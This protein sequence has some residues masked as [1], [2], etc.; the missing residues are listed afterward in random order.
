MWLPVVV[1]VGVER[2]SQVDVK[3]W[4][5]YYVGLYA[6]DYMFLFCKGVSCCKYCEGS[7]LLFFAFLRMFLAALTADSAWPFA[8]RWR[9]LLV[10]CSKPL[11]TIVHGKLIPA[12]VVG[13]Q[14]SRKAFLVRWPSS[15]NY[16]VKQLQDL[17]FAG[18]P[19]ISHWFSTLTINLKVSLSVLTWGQVRSA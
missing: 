18:V 7:P 11:S 10:L 6:S 2:S 19:R 15:Y 8:C 17:I 4:W 13:V 9:G 5:L 16:F 1:K 3:K 12:T 14:H